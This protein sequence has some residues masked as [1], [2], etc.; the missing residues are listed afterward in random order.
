VNLS[1]L[2]QVTL[3]ARS[4]Q[5]LA[6]VLAAHGLGR[7][8]RRAGGAPLKPYGKISPVARVSRTRLRL[9]DRVALHLANWMV[10][11]L[12]AVGGHLGY[13]LPRGYVAQ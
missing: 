11:L 10:T 9:Q 1:R 5:L 8:A 13:M 4:L 7:Q 12:L 2:R 6:S 3:A